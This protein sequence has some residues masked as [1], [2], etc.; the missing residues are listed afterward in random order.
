V[1]A[2]VESALNHPNFDPPNTNPSSTL[3]GKVNTNQ[4]GEG[5]RRMLVGLRLVF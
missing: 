3:F 2:D 5:E 1:R 4:T